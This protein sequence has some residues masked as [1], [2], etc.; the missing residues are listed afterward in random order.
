MGPSKD[1]RTDEVAILRERAKELDCLYS[2]EETLVQAGMTFEEKLTRILQ[3]I[4]A[5]MMFPEVCAVQISLD[6]IRFSSREFEPTPWTL[7]VD[8]MVNRKVVGWLSVF[9]LEERPT[10]DQGP[11]LKEE[12][13]LIRTIAERIGVAI[14]FHRLRESEG[15]PRAAAD[16]AWRASMDLLRRTD[17]NLYVRV[18]RK[19]VNH[20]CG[21]GVKEAQTLLAFAPGE[22]DHSSEVN[23][24]GQRKR[25]D[26]ALLLSERPLA[27]AAQALSGDE[28]LTLVQRWLQEDKA[29]FFL[30]V[31]DRVSSTQPEVADAL[32]R[33]HQVQ[34]EGFEISQNV[35]NGLRVSLI[36][37]LL[38]EQLEYI[39][40][41][42]QYLETRDFEAL[43]DHLIVPSESQGRVGGKS[44]GLFLAQ[45]IID[46]VRTCDPEVSCTRVPKTWYVASDGIKAFLRYN[47]LDD[48]MEQK[49]K[50][51]EIVRQEYPNLVQLFKNSRFPP[52]LIQGLSMALDDFGDKPL[53]V[54]SSSLLEDR[55]GTAF[56]GK[57]KSLFLANQGEKAARLAA[58]L[59]A[60]A[61]IYA[62]VFSPD[63][64][65]YRQDRR[66]IDFNEEMGIL[67]QEV[68]GQKVGDYFLPA[69]AGVAF[70]N[71]EFRWSPRIRRK[72]GLVRLV[73][74]LGTRAV[75]RVSDDYPVLAVPRQ[76]NLRATTSVEEVARY[77]P[78][79]IDVI[80]L[81]ANAFET[82]ELHAFLRIV[83][84]DFPAFEQVMSVLD[85]DRLKV[86]SRLLTDPARD[87]VVVTFDGLLGKTPF[88]QQVGRYLDLLEERMGTPVDIEFAHDG[89]DFYLLQCRPQSN[90]DDS[91]PSPIPKDLPRDDLIFGA[92]RYV[93]NG[94]VP[95]ITHIV[96]VDP[97]RYGEFG[98]HAD[99]V[100]VGRAVGRLNK[101]LPKRQFILMGPGRWGS[102]GDIKLGVGVTYSD[103]SNTAMLIEIARK[104]GNY[105]PDLSFGTHFFQDLVESRIRYLPLYPDEDDV[106]F[107][108]RF[109]QT[110]PSVLDRMLP[111]FG[112]LNDCLR[113]IDVPAATGGRILRI[114]QNA[115]LDEAVAF[116][117]SPQEAP[118][119]E[120]KE[121][122]E[123]CTDVGPP[124]E[125]FWG[126]RLRMAERIA[127]TMDA[128][129][130]GVVAA[131][132]IGSTKNA[133]AGP[134]S[135]ID[136]LIHFRG[137]EAQRAAL[138]TWLDG[139]SR[140]LAEV[141][142]LRTGYRVEH[143]LDAH[144]ITD[145][146]LAD[147]TS[148]AV[149][150]GAI[151]DAARPLPLGA[152]Q[153]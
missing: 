125:N 87:E 63:P 67:L 32:R 18:V 93:S 141:N 116:L 52:E 104:K 42:K 139:W 66:L 107:H 78:R 80:N 142:Y 41:A 92:R 112:H 115:D 4:P 110:A 83:G 3:A 90:T 69:F 91:L 54:R 15:R 89:K 109:L 149:K 99:L 7:S 31:L 53:I 37:R 84:T 44:A 25:M 2:A 26:D 76:P 11:F 55:L 96:Y 135:D 49:Y 27:I 108:E 145:Q 81:R 85:G 21:V 68:V 1:S 17:K 103:I 47:D 20:L 130:L 97:Q 120:A 48:V 128:E 9:Y 140:C 60:V 40:V 124:V 35:V 56:S 148:F 71:N 150:I 8:I 95:D 118:G 100:A 79:Q 152:P 70:S 113:V 29:S 43:F 61:E 34:A 134:G 75:D 5:G 24:P 88:L 122:V 33:F 77:S 22:F 12:V 114:L 16:L 45:C 65:E 131:Y 127:E 147:K 64:I 106:P 73:P 6:G 72:D 102:R 74:G 82:H 133:T 132:L 129:R 14:E 39:M 59:D 13:R 86:A 144:L 51:I 126:W 36:R 57:Y 94:W 136:L 105:S 30:K 98:S 28:I 121:K 111:E 153:A 146:D 23:K 46:R 143:M 117:A 123:A 50:P 138:T 151:T 38:T 137:G 101:I 62:S 58:L 10:L 119:G 19:L